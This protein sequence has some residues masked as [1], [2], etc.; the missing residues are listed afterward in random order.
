MYQGKR[1][2]RATGYSTWRIMIIIGLIYSLTAVAIAVSLTEAEEE[3]P[4]VVRAEKITTTL[5]ESTELINL[6]A[7]IQ[8]EQKQKEEMILEITESSLVMYAAAPT[9]IEYVVESGDTLWWIA[10]H[11]YE[12]GSFYPYIMENNGLSSTNVREGQ[13]LIIEFFDE[14]ERSEILSRCYEKIEGMESVKKSKSSFSTN[15]NG[16]PVNSEFV[17]SFRVTGYDP[18][19]VHCCGKDDGVTASGKQAT[20]GRTIAADKSR[21]PFGTK[22]YIEGLGIFTVEDRGGAIKNNKIDVAVP[23]HDDAYKITGNYNVYIVK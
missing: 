18:Y 16:V 19:C 12:N 1:V 2:R 11:F 8:E 3:N 23:S 20:Y 22:L 4:V 10:N 13:K 5:P 7:M 21:F 15:D 17:G 6:T 14:S 9:N